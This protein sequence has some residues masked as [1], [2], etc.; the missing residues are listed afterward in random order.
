MKI[1]N[2]FKFILRGAGLRIDA[3]PTGTAA[4]KIKGEK[5]G[6]NL[7]FR[8]KLSGDLVFQGVDFDFIN[9]IQESS[10]RCTEIQLEIQR[11]CSGQF[12]TLWTGAFSVTDVKYDLDAGTAKI[13]TFVVN[14]AYRKLLQGASKEYNILA[15]Q[16]RHT[17]AAKLD[18]R[19][20]FEFRYF[21]DRDG[22]GSLPDSDTWSDFLNTS[23]WIDGV[24][25]QNGTRSHANIA[26]R[27]VRTA[28]YTVNTQFP[29]GFV[30]DLSGDGWKIIED[31][32]ST[33]IAKYA[34]RPNVYNFSPFKWETKGD[35][36]K[37]NELRQISCNASFDTN[38]YLPVTGPGRVTSSECGSC[39]NIRYYVDTTRCRT[40]VWEYGTFTF[41][42]NRKLLDVLYYLLQQVDP[43]VCPAS[44]S[45]LSTFFTSATN[46][47]TGAANKLIDLLIAQKTDIIGF[48]SSEPATKGMLS[49]ANLLEDLRN[50]FNVFW[51]VDAT[52]KFK[53]E[54]RSFFSRVGLFDMRTADYERWARGTR[55]FEFDKSK[56][57]RYERLKFSEFFGD[58]FQQ[59]EVEY[60]GDCVNRRENEDTAEITVSRFVTDLQG[61]MINGGSG[62]NTGFVLLAQLNGNVVNELGDLTGQII[63]NGHL[64][65][66]NLFATYHKHGRVLSAGKMNG[67]PTA[68]LSTVHTKKQTSIKFPYCCS[69]T[70]DPFA[71]F[72]TTL[73]DDGE[74]DTTELTLKDGFMKIDVLHPAE[75]D[76]LN[77]LPKRQ[78]NP[79]FN[80]SFA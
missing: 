39:W 7:F 13:G 37:Y 41:S 10:A 56:M 43:A 18:F 57:P 1:S 69:D 28:A 17:V 30:T 77:P 52:G 72:A 74:L 42:R 79:S 67:R 66:A 33:R 12:Q 76:T 71:T 50:M 80:P 24:I 2:Q 31:N 9:S 46:Y 32:A 61:L 15:V 70:V 22:I 21:D 55:Q 19:T 58:D 20:N 8:R 53:I 62:G 48:R 63:S 34:K 36:T 65:A 75:P 47:V 5:E 45:D 40:V 29:N 26:F 60:D 44:P 54:H 23:N 68:F 73:G 51:Y 78:F 64:S 25:G 59:G 27:L 6:A 35:W 11:Q 3:N 4:S 49:L 16:A 38:R 14:D